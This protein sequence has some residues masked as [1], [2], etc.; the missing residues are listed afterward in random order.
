MLDEIE[1]RKAGFTEGARVVLGDGGEWTLPAARPVFYPVVDEGG[2]RTS[3]RLSYGLEFE[4]YYAEAFG[5]SPGDDLEAEIE[6]KMR[7]AVLL[8]LKNYD[9][10]EDAI[11]GLLS[12]RAGD[13]G[14]L[15]MWARLN[16]A[17][18][19]GATL[20]LDVT[21]AIREGADDE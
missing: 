16:Q 3:A 2:I 8:L 4:P 9:L 7:L 12:I 5:D 6:T 17:I 1:S 20:T 19:E 21:D 14:S 18:R 13:L 11:A 10:D 15:E